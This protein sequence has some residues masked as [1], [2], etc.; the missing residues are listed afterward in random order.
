MNENIDNIFRD[1]LGNV[2]VPPAPYVKTG[3]VKKVS[4]II[5]R[6]T[7]FSIAI[8]TTS[9]G[10]LVITSSLVFQNEKKGSNDVPH[11]PDSHKAGLLSLNNSL[12]QPTSISNATNTKDD[13]DLEF[14]EDDT[15]KELE[16]NSS[17]LLAQKTPADNE[18]LALYS[19]SNY[20]KKAIPEERNSDVFYLESTDNQTRRNDDSRDNGITANQLIE[21]P[22]PQAHFDSN[23]KNEII[24]RENAKTN[25]G[26][27]RKSKKA[28]QPTAKYPESTTQ[29]NLSSL[30]EASELTDSKFSIE[31]DLA[32]E[33]LPVSNFRITIG[34]SN[35]LIE[36]D[37]IYSEL[38]SELENTPT[39][40]HNS[41]PFEIKSNKK[42]WS[43][44]IASGYGDYSN[45]LNSSLQNAD[46]QRATTI[47]SKSNYMGLFTSRELGRFKFSLG[48][49]IERMSQSYSV[50]TI[51]RT[52]EEIGSY[53]NLYEVVIID[54]NPTEVYMGQEYVTSLVEKEEEITSGLTN[55]IDY[56]QI[57]FSVG[58][59]LFRGS[60][61]DAEF[62]AG[63]IFNHKL[64]S[65]GHVLNEVT[66]V[67]SS[68][69]L[70]KSL[71]N[72][73]LWHYQ[74]GITIN[75]SITERISVRVNPRLRIASSK[76][77]D[78]LRI[79]ST[80]YSGLDINFGLQ[81]KL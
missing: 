39:D 6:K 23:S 81:I 62:S 68:L 61:F 60:R 32:N 29:R 80:N 30:E 37:K 14:I 22:K 65:T 33:S 36:L 49:G 66:G 41:N 11:V 3:L 18:G 48:S 15:I 58:Y 74:M 27:S 2:Q 75:R 28:K 17:K 25:N 16:S 77:F 51:S 19:L 47:N 24:L 78:E 20:S 40:I 5:Y 46:V 38:D 42:F 34:T 63:V 4:S 55:Q 12:G 56:L 7:L 64:N 35:E 21:I 73:S 45:S 43:I 13:C 8:I 1:N 50:S 57:P 44:G 76:Q 52:E 10:V 59:D 69:E 67:I 9:V 79:Q 70:D 72:K 54:G 71:V 26:S 31:E 53:V